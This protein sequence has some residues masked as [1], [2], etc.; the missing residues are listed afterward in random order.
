MNSFAPGFRPGA[1]LYALQDARWP[2]VLPVLLMV[3]SDYDW[4]QRAQTE[5]LSGTPDLAVMLEVGVYA[6]VGLFLL[7]V[8]IRRPARVRPTA[9][10]VALWGYGMTMTVS[11]LLSP[12]PTMGTVRGGQLIV[13]C[14][15]AAMLSGTLRR[16]HIDDMFHLFLVV[17][18]V[19]VGIGVAFP[20]PAVTNLSADRFTWLYV[21]PTQSAIYLA[22]AIVI[23]IGLSARPTDQMRWPRGVYLLLA[24]I[25]AFSLY[26]STTRGSIAG[27]VAG[28]IVL[29]LVAS[30]SRT[31]PYR[32]LM[33]IGALVLIILVAGNSLMTYLARGESAETLSTLNSRTDLWSEAWR[34]FSERPVSG[35]G[36]GSTRGLFL[37][38][39]NLGGGHNSFINVFVDGGAAGLIWWF[40]WLVC[41]VVAVRR[42]ARVPGWN[43]DVPIIAG[44]LGLLFVN[45]MTVDGLGAVANVCSL[46]LVT[47]TG[48]TAAALNAS[49]ARLS[50]GARSGSGRRAGGDAALAR[51]RPVPSRA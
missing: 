14:L 26:R 27:V 32:I 18:A 40:A 51:L 42:M 35:W 23:A 28:L 39:L 20:F 15:L 46:W 17:V 5:S 36:L 41:L 1:A 9:A 11:A 21:H 12:F 49:P 13:M 24:F 19:S 34:L 3:V 30:T 16:E 50:P 33:V 4:R 7:S 22:I 43:R 48:W 31:R 38:T 25:Y 45:G 37:D 6:V 44:I 10:L 47:I 2:V 8:F 29:T